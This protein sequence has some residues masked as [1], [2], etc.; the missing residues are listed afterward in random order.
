MDTK[1]NGIEVRKESGY[2]RGPKFYSIPIGNQNG[3]KR[4]ELHELMTEVFIL[5]YLRSQG[6]FHNL[7]EDEISFLYRRKMKEETTMGLMEN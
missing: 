1:I 4:D 5:G 3:L 7:T 2:I 6:V